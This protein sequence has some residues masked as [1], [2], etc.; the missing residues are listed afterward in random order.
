MT[1]G[2][3]HCATARPAAPAPAPADP[4]RWPD[5]AAPPAASRPRTAIAAAV[6]RHALRRLPLR[7]R[8][9]DKAVLGQG[10][11]ALDIHRPTAFHGRIGRHGLIGFGESYMAGEWDAPDLVAALT[12]L[13][14]H[15][16]ELV[17]APLQRLRGLWA[18]RQPSARRNTP[19][20]S[21]ANISHH[22]DLSNDL[23]ALFLDETL[24]YSSAVFRI[25]PAQ[26]G[27]LAD[28]QRRKIDRL[29]DLA[30][31]GEGSRVLE[32][33]TGWGELAL[34]AAARGAQVTSLT[35]SREQ[36]D[37]ARER[38]AAAGLSGRVEVE[39]CDYR[40][41]RGT[42]DAVVSVEM[43]EAVGAEF[44]PVY[45][46]TL[47]ERLAPGGR[48]VLQAITMPHDRM[49]ASRS[50]YTWIQKYIFPGGLLPSV[51]AVAET[52]RDHTRLTVARRDGYGAH[53][54]ETLRL[55]RERFTE[56]ADEVGVLGFDETFRRMWTFYLAYSEAGF[57][58]GYLDVQQYL[59]TK[60]DTVR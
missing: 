51:D 3:A 9:A 54:A 11:P 41:A 1:T 4:V 45:F 37:L 23:F 58:S 57:R 59:L 50:T 17:P 21:R 49:L 20:G 30:G 22:Y 2:G 8:F 28:A 6:V 55:W 5:V 32:I 60:E 16:P 38:I 42:Y 53:Y 24:S 33:G 10:G 19:V 15:A 35:L 34:R 56:R 31:V 7:V 43:I 27:L 25:L 14:A 47:D 48:A 18:L 36:R 44:W 40:E 52:V 29:L 26:W 46:R 12:V 13:A 39:L